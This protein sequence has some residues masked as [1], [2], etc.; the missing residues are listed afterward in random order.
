MGSSPEDPLTGRPSQ[1]LRSIQLWMH[2]L[3]LHL[4]CWHRCCLREPP[5]VALKLSLILLMTHHHHR[6]HFYLIFLWSLI[7]RRVVCLTLWSVCDSSRVVC[8]WSGSSSSC[9]GCW[10]AMTWPW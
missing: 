10:L 7:E 3:F 4:H 5:L 2:T 6:Q 8:V 1:L 9:W